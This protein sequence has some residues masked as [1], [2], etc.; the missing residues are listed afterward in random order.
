MKN[1]PQAERALGN[2]IDRKS[3]KADKQELVEAQAE[4]A[5][6]RASR[7]KF[8]KTLQRVVDYSNTLPEQLYALEKIGKLLADYENEY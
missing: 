2:L 6:L 7:R 8:V 4:I 5:R 3:K 1:D